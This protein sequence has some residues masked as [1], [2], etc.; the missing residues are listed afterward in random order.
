VTSPRTFLRFACVCVWLSACWSPIMQ[1]VALKNSLLLLFFACVI[2]LVTCPK[3]P[4]HPN[5]PHPHPSE[6]DRQ[7][8]KYIYECEKTPSFRKC[9]NE[10]GCTSHGVGMH[11][12]PIH[13]GYENDQEK[14]PCE[15]AYY[16]CI[17]VLNSC[18]DVL[19]PGCYVNEDGSYSTNPSH[20]P[21]SPPPP[22]PHTSPSP[23]PHSPYD[24]KSPECQDAI[25]QCQAA[26]SHTSCRVDAGCTD[27]KNKDAC[28]HADSLCRDV[29]FNCLKFFGPENC[30]L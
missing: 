5:T 24:D 29:L 25:A 3:V 15:L 26:T 11:N 18:L 14:S 22:P 20:S 27:I 4:P 28:S 23:P 8:Q 16:A 12:P 7:C 2:P 10:S 1:P 6:F 19:C 13:H 9:T 21:A 17:P 30:T